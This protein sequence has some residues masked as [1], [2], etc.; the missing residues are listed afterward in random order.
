MFTI[1]ITEVRIW[2]VVIVMGEV[3]ITVFYIGI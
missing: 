2:I 3:A 1:N